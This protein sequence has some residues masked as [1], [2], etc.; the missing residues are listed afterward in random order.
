L[1][2]ILKVIDDEVMAFE[3][4][5]IYP[6]TDTRLSGLSHTEQVRRL[7]DGGATLIQLREKS[8]DPRTF[9]TDAEAALKVAQKNGVKLIINDRVDIAMALGADGIHLG[10]TDLPPAIAR[11]L[12]GPDSIIGFSTHN[13]EQV[14]EAVTLPV[15]YVAFGPVFATATKRD[16]DAV[17]GLEGLA[18]ARSILADIPL[19]AIGGISSEK[20]LSVIQAGA[21]SVAIISALISDPEQIS[22]NYQRFHA[23]LS[24]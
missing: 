13:R 7:I 16:P 14:L 22:A 8:L 10:Q 20:V 18:S 23:N 6:I 12:V 17:A 3:L 9:L 11:R 4:P 15:N 19:V 2:E 24:K 1:K 21:D 5:R